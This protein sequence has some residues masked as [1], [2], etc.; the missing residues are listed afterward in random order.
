MRN[1]RVFRGVVAALSVLACLCASLFDHDLTRPASALDVEY[2]PPST[3]VT[4]PYVPDPGYGD[5]E[6]AGCVTLDQ[7]A[8]T[9]PAA[10][11]DADPIGMTG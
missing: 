9:A 1:P 5:C 4:S 2:V 10:P 6:G 8:T 3:T 11:I 7:I